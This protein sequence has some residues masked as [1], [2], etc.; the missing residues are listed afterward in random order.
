M[1]VVKE[2]ISVT[3]LKEMAEN[4]FGN[5]VKDDSERRDRII[6]IVNKLLIE[7]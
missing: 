6:K 7:K 2:N 4:M 1:I 3:R 5:L